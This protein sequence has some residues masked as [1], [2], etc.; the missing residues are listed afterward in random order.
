MNI[1]HCSENSDMTYVDACIYGNGIILLSALG[2]IA[3]NK[4][5]IVGWIVGMKA[6][7]AMCSLIYRKVNSIILWS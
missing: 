7:I 3:M 5:L 1:I 6:R 4:F 2:A